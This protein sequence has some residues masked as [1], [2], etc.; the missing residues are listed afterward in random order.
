MKTI[1]WSRTALY[2]AMSIGLAALSR[3]LPV[4][5][6]VAFGRTRL[7]AAPSAGRLTAEKLLVECAG[8]RGLAVFPVVEHIADTALQPFQKM[9]QG[10]ERHVLFAHFH[11]LQRG[12]GNS[13]LA[14]KRRVAQIAAFFPQKSGELSLQGHRHEGSVRRMFSHMWERCLTA[15]SLSQYACPPTIQNWT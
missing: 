4:R 13:K 11:A 3:G 10:L 9:L 7:R 6:A 2:L 8:R 12:R 5:R 15:L 1:Y 14:G